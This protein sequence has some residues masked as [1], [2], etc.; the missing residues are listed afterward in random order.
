[1]L[2]FKYVKEDGIDILQNLRL[3]VK[4]AD[5]LNDP[6]ELLP[7]VAKPTKEEWRTAYGSDNHR[8]KLYNKGII[9][10]Q[11]NCSYE[12]FSSRLE[13]IS[14]D[15]EQTYKGLYETIVKF[16]KSSSRFVRVASFCSTSIQ[17][18]DDVLMWAH[19]ANNRGMRISFDTSKLPIHPSNLVEVKY[20]E[21]R[22]LI[23]PLLYPLGKDEENAAQFSNILLVKSSSWCYEKEYRWLIHPKQCQGSD[24]YMPVPMDSIVAI[25]VGV[26]SEATFFQQ[27]KLSLRTHGFEHVILRQATPN[28]QHFKYDYEVVMQGV[29]A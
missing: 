5:E 8:Q 12:E 18:E 6:F 27:V 15:E 11:V 25:D 13:T 26:R 22:P 24:H 2:L 1:M 29:Q 28:H 10:G 19:Y 3:L 17:P 14:I 20:S 21:N 23:N 4:A 7:A 16:Q 9:S